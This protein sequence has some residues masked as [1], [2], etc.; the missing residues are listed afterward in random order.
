M[1]VQMDAL[2]TWDLVELPR[3]KTPMG[4]RWVFTVKYK[5]DGSLKSYKARLVVKGY[6]Q[7]YGIDYCQEFQA[8]PTYGNHLRGGGEQ[9]DGLF[10]ANLNM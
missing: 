9:G 2:A 5:E 3:K 10:F 4:Y 6:T 1:R 8:N 7:T